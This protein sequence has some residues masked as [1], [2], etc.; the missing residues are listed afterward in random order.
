MTRLNGRG[1]SRC[2]FTYID[3]MVLMF[4]IVPACSAG[5]WGCRSGTRQPANRVKCAS[6]LR[7]IGQA[8]LLYA[9][10]NS[11]KYPRA[12]YA[13]GEDVMPTFFTGAA[14][15]DPFKPD[16]P[17]PNDVTAALFLL[18][19]TQDITSEVFTCP[20][21][22]AEKDLFGGGTNA[23]INRS[24][25]SGK[26][27]LSY[28]MHNPYVSDGVV[29]ADDKTYWTTNMSA[30]FAVAAD[31]NP[32]T[33]PAASDDVLKP[34]NVSSAK[35]MRLGNSNNHD[36]D[37][38]N[39]LYGDGHVAWEASPFVGIDRDNIFAAADGNVVGSPVTMTDSVLLPT[40]D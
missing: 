10:D 34:T 21:T 28:S 35:D 14:A 13:T 25:F 32:G 4:I 11:G 31:L 17:Q 30:E 1:R 39:I 19:R 15:A 27:N 26:V 23:P 16:G 6:N 33:A 24:N 2:A 3:L 22:E 29:P 37:G 7:Q 18:L 5:F 8:M 12:T 38:Q 36:K 40:D 9:N 20:S